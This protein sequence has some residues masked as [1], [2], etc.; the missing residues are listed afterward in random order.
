MAHVIRQQPFQPEEE[1]HRLN[2]RC[3]FPMFLPVPNQ[4]GTHAHIRLSAFARL[5]LKDAT[6]LEAGFNS[7]EVSLPIILRQPI[8]A[9]RCSSHL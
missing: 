9:A 3:N 1:C 5:I 6:L 8:K 4:L 7:L 2:R